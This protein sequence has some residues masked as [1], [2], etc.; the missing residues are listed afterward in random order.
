MWQGKSYRACQRDLMRYARKREVPTDRPWRRLAKRH[1]R[2][3]IEGEGGWR[4][5]VWYG[6]R[7]FFDWLETKSYKMHIRVLLSK[8]RAYNPCPDCGGARLK[9]AALDWRVGDAADAERALGDRPRFRPAGSALS[10]TRLRE[11]PGLTIHDV[12]LLPL[13]AC[14]RLFESVRLPAPMDEATVLLLDEVRTR[15]RYLVSVGLGY[16]TLDR[17]SRT[18]S[19]GEVQRINLTTALGTSLVNALFVLD[20]PS[21][22]LHARD[23]RRVVDVLHRLRDAGNT[24]LVVEHD[25]QVMLAAD[26]VLDIGPGPGERG[27]E[28][29]FFGPPDALL[30]HGTSLTAQYLRDERRVSEH[31]APQ[32]TPDA[33]CLEI[34]GATE[35]NLKNIDVHIPLRRLVCVTGVSGSGKSTLVEDICHRGL[36]KLGG[37][38]SDPAGAHRGIRGHER[39]GDVVMIDQSPI[40]K[41]ARSNPASYVGALDAIRKVFAREPL[42][43]ERAYTAG[44][45]SFNSGSGALS[46]LRGHRL[47]AHRNAVPERRVPALPGLRRPALPPRSPRGQGAPAGRGTGRRRPGLLDCRRARDDR[48]TGDCLLP[49]A[50]GRGTCARAP[51]G[52]GPRLHAARPAGAFPERRRGAAPQARRPPRQGPQGGRGT[53]IGAPSSFSTNRPPGFTSTTSRLS[54]ARCA[55]SSTKATPWWSSSTTSTWSGLRTGSSTSG[56]KAETRAAS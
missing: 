31:A 22:G 39:L 19:G 56:R 34:L 50:S 23:M 54:S 24:L 45:F 6:V 2:W 14:A 21:I 29:V 20:E 41:T 53:R 51:G 3:V 15:L 49:R 30:G 13:E 36:R 27:G 40:G 12:V 7:R 25:A 18:L 38:A 9:P 55:A 11:L 4:R 26:R 17:Q 47:R 10:E 16:L 46:H 28:V 33:G 37:K 42:A 52:G 8:Y 48:G 44:T 5:G 32:R 35:H 43:A 1:R